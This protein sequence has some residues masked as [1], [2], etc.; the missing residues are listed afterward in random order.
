MYSAHGGQEA[1]SALADIIYGDV[2]PGGRLTQTWHT[3][4]KEL[5]D[6]MNYD[7]IKGKRTYKYFV[8]KPLFPFGHGLSYTAFRYSDLSLSSDSIKKDGSVTIRVNV[9]NTGGRKGDEVVQLYTSPLFKTRVKQPNLDL[10]DFQRVE[11]APKETKTVTFKLKQTDLAFW[12]V[13]RETF[14]VERGPY[15]ISVG[16]SR[17]RTSARQSGS[18]SK[19]KQFGN[20]TCAERQTL[21]TTT[22]T[23]AC[24][25]PKNPNTAAMR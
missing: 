6:M 24:S 15:R 13:T 17:R 21:K 20:G 2:N 10:K 5:P 1:G 12:D 18:S 9:T 25:S 23:K 3:S 7:I 11:L 22:T 4:V 8:G 14:A 16:A 19:A